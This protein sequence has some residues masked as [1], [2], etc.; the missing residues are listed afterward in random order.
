M[1]RTTPIVDLESGDSRQL[2]RETLVNWLDG[3]R[4]SCCDIGGDEVIE[5]LDELRGAWPDGG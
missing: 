5:A 2:K 3:I 1:P 4:R